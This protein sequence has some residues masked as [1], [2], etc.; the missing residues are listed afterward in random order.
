MG[1]IRLI[2]RQAPSAAAVV[3]ALLWELFKRIFVFYV[4]NFSAVG[5]VMSK[6]NARVLPT[7]P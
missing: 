2:P 6:V 3:G 4:A 7:A 1:H 5:V